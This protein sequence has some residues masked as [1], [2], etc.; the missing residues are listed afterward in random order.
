MI[1]WT[2]VQ[3]SASL[4]PG[5][6]TLI[7]GASFCVCASSGDISP[8]GTDGVFFCDTRLVSRWQLL[9][10]GE[11]VEPMTVVPAQPFAATFV[12]RARARPN[13]AETTLL[14]TRARYVGAGLR[15][16]IAV[17]NFAEE[18]AGIHVSL[19]VESDLADIFDVKA[20]RVTDGGQRSVEVASDGLL[21]SSHLRDRAR[22]VR[23]SAMDARVSPGGF[24]F[25]VVVQPRETWRATV[26]AQPLINGQ[27][28]PPRFPPDRPIE[29][30]RPVRRQHA[31]DSATPVAYMQ[32]ADLKNTLRRSRTDLGALRIFDARHPGRTSVAAGAPWFM[33]LFGRDSL[34]TSLMALSLDQSLGR[35]TLQMLAD[36]QGEH[37]EPLTEEEPGKI[38]HELR[39]SGLGLGGGT[40]PGAA[41]AS[42]YFGSV[43]A[44]PLFVILLGE[45]RRWGLPDEIFEQL[46]PH[47]DR[48][49]QWMEKF[50]DMDGDGFIEY[51]R[52]TDRGLA[53]QGWKDSS[54]GINFADGTLAQAPIALAEVQGYA[55]AAYLSRAHIA[56][57]MGDGGTVERYTERADSL[58]RAFNEA[59]W[60]PHQ[61]WYAVGLDHDKKPIDALASNMGHCLFTGIADPDKAAAVAEHLMSPEMFTGWGVRTLSS[62]MRAYNPMSYH[63]GSVWPHDNALMAAGLMRYGFVE[64]AQR[65]AMGLFDAAEAFSGRLPELFCGFDRAEYSRPV[66]YP[67]AC[68]PQAWASATPV[69]LLR[70][71]MRFD[72]CMP[73]R[74]IWLAPAFPQGLGQVS[75]DRLSLGASQVSVR[76]S[77]DQIDVSGLPPGIELIREP[78]PPVSAGRVVGGH[79]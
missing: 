3:E 20:S 54:D 38:I 47:A 76:A 4:T 18:P 9:V 51:R 2:A 13:R 59:F 57:D 69:F 53:N 15:E 24:S 52:K 22:G 17:Q 12:G 33:T 32:N 67:T 16:D 46:L 50:G 34:I 7:E 42:A 37:V 39:H 48:A 5:A 75:I 14:V 43:D 73:C 68:S 49:L 64:H 71:L 41:R 23:I 1:E 44:T 45:L 21:V 55:Y 66:S 65:I 28:L 19:Q 72:P 79:Q 31:W 25:E 70:V 74:K 8:G 61:G 27:E 40:A 26:L 6:V 35:G 58:K 29:C 77:G 36:L 56:K 11:P 63:N 78:Q 62:S 30:A 60:L 10:D